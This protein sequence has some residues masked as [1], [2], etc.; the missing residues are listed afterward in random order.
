M[1]DPRRGGRTGLPAALRLPGHLRRLTWPPERLAAERERRLRA[2]L[3][4]AFRHAPYHRERLRGVDLDRF[5]EADLQHLPTMTKADV[6]ARWDDLVTDPHLRLDAVRE[7][8][9]AKREGPILDRYRAFATGGTS[10]RTGLFLYTAEAWTTAML[11]HLRINVRARLRSPGLLLERP[12]VVSIVAEGKA[13]LSS[14]VAD[15]FANAFVETH[16]FAVTERFDE[17]LARIER[18]RPTTLVTYGS[19]F[20]DLVAEAERGRFRVSP[21]MI[22]S[23]SDPLAPAT[24]AA[25]ERL[26]TPRISNVWATTE[27]GPTAIGCGEGEGMHLLDDLVIYE[28]VDHEHRPVPPGAVAAKVLVTV[29]TNEVLPLVRYELGDE[30]QLLE[31]PC[32]CGSTHRRVADIQG[33]TDD[34]FRWGD[35]RVDAHLFRSAFSMQTAIH[36]YQVHQTERGADV[37]LAV[38]GPLDTDAL[39]RYLAGRLAGQG[40]KD[41]VVRVRLVDRIE[42]V[43][44]G[45]KV[46][47]FVPLPA[48][49]PA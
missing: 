44:T 40:L 19:M 34:A 9:R 39:A 33:R 22:V 32:A 48:L 10:G 3:L 18:I 28:L 24:R 36:Q 41:A 20:A 1:R 31:E 23:T 46:R 30:V 37:L 27:V 38:D 26:W 17:L 16:R 35:L 29:L 6:M 47:Y 5:T 21:S 43:G 11:A 42:R 13:H 4:H 25:I 2:L 15:A 12:R 49:V 7:H 8:V 14:A 45:G